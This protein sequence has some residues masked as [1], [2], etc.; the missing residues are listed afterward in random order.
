MKL[1]YYYSI[2][3]IIIL[4]AICNKCDSCN[5]G[6]GK[7]SG[8]SSGKWGCKAL[9][10]VEKCKEICSDSYNYCRVNTFMII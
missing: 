1:L 4:C 3:L 10:Q 8:K 6:C 9:N 5:K 2:L 7:S